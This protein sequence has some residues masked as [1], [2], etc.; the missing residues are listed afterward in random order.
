MAAP[1][2]DT[3]N[4]IATKKIMP[5]LA[6]NFFKNDP[7]LAFLKSRFQTWDGPE[8]QENLVFKPMKGGPYRKGVGGFDISKRQTITGVRFDP[9]Y[10]QVSVSEFLEDIEVEM[11]GETAV[12]S[13]VKTD[14]ANASLTMA[15]IL[16][17]A[18]YRHGQN[19]VADRTAHL[20]GLE[21]FL[22]DGTNATW[23]G[24]T[25]GFTSYGKQPRADVNR[26]L[27]SPAGLI[28]ANVN[29]SAT[30]R[31][32]EHSYLSCVIGEEHPVIGVT[33]NRGMGYIG[34]NFQPLQK[35]DT[36]EPTIGYTGIKFKKATIVE[37]QYCPGAD[38]IN[39]PDIGDYSAAAETFWWLNPGPAGEDAYFKLRIAAS[40]KFQFGFTGF[41][42]AQDATQ[43]AGQILFG[44][45]CTGRAPRLSRALFGIT[46]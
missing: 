1:V 37:S 24:A 4:T 29:G 35:V 31:V 25:G 18:L 40:P 11:H 3:I 27:N 16:A 26:A 45:N 38:G 10:Y 43:V 12:L 44:G 46:G 39:D 42:V 32:F 15:A 20:N 21:E 14:L 5:S 17:V 33:T 2:L 30:Y 9:K 41:K 23:S 6:D 28:A 7:L 13:L 36:V 8:I 22:A 19:V 34:E